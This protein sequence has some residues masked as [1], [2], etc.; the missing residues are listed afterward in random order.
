MKSPF[1]AA[2]FCALSLTLAVP[3]NP[4]TA[5]PSQ[6]APDTA[7]RAA[8][9]D[10]LARGFYERNG[11]R[12]IWDARRAD[13]LIAA[14]GQARRHGMDGQR[15]LRLVEGASGPAAREAALTQAAMAYGHALAFGMVDPSTLHSLYTLD[16]PT[17]DLIGGLAK[18]SQSG[19]IGGWLESL[20]P[21]DAEYRALSAAYLDN[22]GKM[23][24][25]PAKPVPAGKLLKPGGR[26]PRVALI[27]Q[28]LAAAGYSVSTDPTNPTLYTP[29]MADAVRSLQADR[30]LGVDGVIGAGTLAALNVQPGAHARQLALNLER[31]RWLARSP[32]PRRI[33]VNTAA[34]QLAY[35]RDGQVVHR[36]R[37][38]VGKS[39]TATPPLASRMTRLVVN[40][41]WY[42]PTSIAQKEILPKGSAYLRREDMY[43]ENG[44]VIQRPGP[45]AA[46]GQVKFDLDNPYAIYLHDTPSKALFDKGER[47]ASHGCVRV[48][49][50]LAF[51]RMLADEDGNGALFDEKLASGKTGVVNFERD[52]PV[53]LLYHT[54]WVDE[55]GKVA[56]APDTYG[57]DEKLAVALGMGASGTRGAQPVAADVG[58]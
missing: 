46:L 18:A 47:H 39:D 45:K 35:W 43:V 25:A 36:A 34:T 23:D 37:V 42:V 9:T 5:Q 24:A 29:Q 53:R 26:D 49:D 41:P 51:A 8:V 40:P 16:R 2:L 52:I 54:A 3:G 31:R 10:P 11:W 38:V 12:P 15:F 6:A 30:G 1:R 57:W 13:A 22:I 17:A 50:A 21:S 7:L 48:Q 44:R 58:P 28:A 33:D 27:A 20:A 32:A 14:I 4:V 55:T 19:D 56:Y